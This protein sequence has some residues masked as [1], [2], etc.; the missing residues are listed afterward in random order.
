M[1]VAHQIVLKLL[2]DEEDEEGAWKEVSPDVAAAD[3]QRWVF[4]DHELKR[5][6]QV[7]RAS[8]EFYVGVEGCELEVIVRRDGTVTNRWGDGTYGVPEHIRKLAD[9]ED[10][11]W[12]PRRARQN[13]TDDYHAANWLDV[14]VD[15]NGNFMGFVDPRKNRQESRLN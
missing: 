1:I 8:D 2:E 12:K 11:I 13:D 6:P 10:V 5:Y 14:Y 15:R 7:A 4:T 9:Q 3:V